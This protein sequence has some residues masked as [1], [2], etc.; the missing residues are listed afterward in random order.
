MDKLRLTL[1]DLEVQSFATSSADA[2]PRSTVHA[3]Q[4]TVPTGIYAFCTCTICVAQKV[5]SPATPPPIAPS[6][7]VPKIGRVGLS[8]F[9]RAPAYLPLNSVSD[10]PLNDLNLLQRTVHPLP[11]VCRHA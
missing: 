4:V 11:H 10:V 9:A 7:P 6:T 8:Y 5:D 1:S 3:H 2:Q